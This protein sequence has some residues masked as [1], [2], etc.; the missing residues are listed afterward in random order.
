MNDFSAKM[1]QKVVVVRVLSCPF[2]K[3]WFSRMQFFFISC[4]GKCRYLFSGSVFKKELQLFPC[5]AYFQNG[6][7]CRKKVLLQQKSSCSSFLV[8]A[9]SKWRIF[10]RK[11]LTTITQEFQVF[12]CLAYF[13][14]GELFREK[15]LTQQS[16]SC[17]SFRFPAIFIWRMFPRKGLTTMTNKFQVFPCLAY[18]Q[19][20]GL[21]RKEVF[22]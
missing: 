14:N 20:G 13:Q 21:F 11:G 22:L 18:F 7:L 9:I 5:L 6:G 19:N 8:L 4:L 1:Y 3:W 12:P 2:T 17:S 15:V 16:S 10:P